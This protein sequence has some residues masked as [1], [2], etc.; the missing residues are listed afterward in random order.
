M[1]SPHATLADP[2][3][4]THTRAPRPLQGLSYHWHPLTP[5]STFLSALMEWTNTHPPF[6]NFMFGL[7]SVATHRKCSRPSF[8]VLLDEG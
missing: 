8:V 4:A 1:P 3:P 5:N 6:A 2:C 7:V